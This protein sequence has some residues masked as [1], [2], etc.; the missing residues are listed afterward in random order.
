[1][2]SKISSY[3]DKFSKNYENFA[4]KQSLGTNYLNRIERDF[5][6]ESVLVRKGQKVLDIGVGTGR[7]AALLLDKGAIVEGIDISKR[8]MSEAKKKLKNERVNFT[9]ADASKRIPFKN[10]TFDHVICI[11]VLKYMPLWKNLINEVSRV[12]KKDGTFSFDI[13]NLYSVAYF[14]LKTA[15]YSLF[16]YK[17]VK[18]TLEAR[19]FKIIKV[20]SGSRLPFPLYKK[21]NNK[22]IFIFLMFSERILNKVLPKTILSRSVLLVCKRM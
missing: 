1:M 7:N 22:I 20:K 10:N 9:L 18:K 19:G 8:M 3:F 17:E 13:A 5:I 16:R 4:F 14:G 2:K 21:I 11:R 12:L 15:N 6:L